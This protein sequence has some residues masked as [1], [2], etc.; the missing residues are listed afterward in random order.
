MPRWKRYPAANDKNTPIEREQPAHEVWIDLDKIMAVAHAET[1]DG[2]KKG[3]EIILPS[4]SI[5]VEVPAAKVMRDIAEHDW[6]LNEQLQDRYPHDW[7]IWKRNVVELNLAEL[8]KGRKPKDPALSP[9]EID[10]ILKTGTE[11][12]EADS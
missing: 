10:A 8:M 9:E 7:P 6:P 1:F 11:E 12:K 4:G 3:A 2:T 5:R